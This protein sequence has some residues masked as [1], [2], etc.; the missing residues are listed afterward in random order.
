MMRLHCSALNSNRS[1][2]FAAVLSCLL[3]TGVDADALDAA[4]KQDGF[5]AVVAEALAAYD[6]DVT[7]NLNDRDV[8]GQRIRRPRLGRFPDLPLDSLPSSAEIDAWEAEYLATQIGGIA[9]IAN[10][11]GG[12][13]EAPS[14]FLH[15]WLETTS[16]DRLF[17]TF[18]LED[19]P[20][21]AKIASVAS[22][23][24]FSVQL[25]SDGKKQPLVGNLFA[26][27][28][29]RLAID[30]QAARRYSSQVTELGYLSRRVRK[31]TESLFVDEGNKGE[32][33][34]ARREPAVFLK[35]TLGDAFNQS[36][37]REVVVPGGVA[38]GASAELSIVPKSLI[39][40]E[41]RWLIIDD[42]EVSWQLP[43]LDQPGMKALFDFVQRS[44][45]IK[46][47]AIVDIDADGRVRISTALRDTEVGYQIMHADTQPFKYVPNLPVTKSVVIDI[48]VSWFPSS[49]ERA[50]E[51]DTGYEVRFLSADNMR[52]AQ[53]RVALE[54]QY[55][56]ATDGVAYKNAW[57][58]D[59]RRLHDNLDYAGLGNSLSGVA[60]YAGWI[61]LL[62]KLKEDRIPF[63]QGRYEFMKIDKR[64][65]ETPA[66]Y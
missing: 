58:R 45:S 44:Q 10:G 33:S 54:Y 26:T 31:N 32:S 50:L 34:L 59:V 16:A 22:A 63:L 23:Y 4:V 53:T 49:V 48:D 43:P 8:V 41:G 30:T 64:G 65:R 42:N 39:F 40:A 5:L 6:I 12:K 1:R 15:E 29:Q 13:F 7:S 37:I 51:F 27:A 24:D 2:F 57:G 17:I 60:N 14:E 35:Q 66:R 38:L 52:I 19:L 18:Y 20:A 46:S 62:R 36:T 11:A 56:S 9:I 47:D 3:V 21:A 25:F 28:A 55:H 61:G